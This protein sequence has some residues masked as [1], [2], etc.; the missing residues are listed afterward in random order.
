M[1]TVKAVLRKK[2]NKDGK[3][4][5]AIRITKNRKTSYIYTGKYVKLEEWDVQNQSVKKIHPSSARINNYL[6]KKLAQADDKDLEMEGQNKILS[7]K[8]LKKQIK[9][10]GRITTFFELADTY[11]SN[12][13][14]AGKYSRYITEKTRVKHFREFFN[15]EG[16]YFQEVTVL[17]LKRFQAYLKRKGLSDRSV[18]NNMIVIR[19]IFNLAIR[20]GIVD[21]QVYP[22]GK[23]KI[24]TKFPESAKIGL[25]MEEV[26][27][28]EVLDLVVGSP[29]WHSRNVWLFSF[30][31][32]GMR[33]S[34]VLKIKWSN[35]QDDRLHYVMGKNN[36]VG[37]LK[38]PEKAF[39]IIKYYEKESSDDF[40]FPELKNA[41]V[42]S[43]KDIYRK[44]QTATKKFNNYLFEIAKLA[45]IEKKITMHIARHTFGN[46]SGDKIPIQMLQ[47][48]YRHTSITTTIGYQSNFMY[49]DADD[50]LE[51]VINS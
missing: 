27:K 6:K 3:Y 5:I 43:E 32:A 33:V 29:I 13:E 35:F 51:A 48:L 19:T 41:Q 45:E 4:P 47:K 36:K 42:G 23:G 2:K 25:T 40:I 22:F 26:N 10:D 24:V 37:S 39:N 14:Q 21:K 38:I 16:L 50:A 28:I 7:A 12:M 18:V 20:E 9:N 46:I 30:Y 49:K 1:A 34:D 8:S 11:L 31:L 17:L 15:S 44:T